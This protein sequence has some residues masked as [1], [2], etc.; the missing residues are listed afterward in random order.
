[1]S[2]PSIPQTQRALI[3]SWAALGRRGSWH[4]LLRRAAALLLALTGL[5]ASAQQPSP[6][7]PPEARFDVFEYRVEG[8]SVLPVETIERAVYPFLGERRT[9]ADVESARA[10][11]EA[12]YRNAGYGTVGVDTPE[13]KITD[14]VVTLQ[15]VQAPVSRLRVVGAKYYSQ[16]RILEKVPSLA[17]G[18]VPNFKLA[19]EQLATV[20]RSADRRVTPL[21][22]PGKTPGTTEVDLVVEDKAPLHGSIELNNKASPNTTNLRLQAS[23]RYDNLWQLEHSIGVQAQVS[24]EDTSQVR[25]FSGSYSV[26][27]GTGLLVFSAIRSNS[28]TVA[29]IGDTSVFGRGSIYGLHRVVVLG[30]DESLSQT[31]TF[32]ADYKNFTESVSVG[33]NQ[34]F[35]TPIHYLPLSLGYAATLTDKQGIWQAGAG[36]ELAVRGLASSEAQFADKRF[37][38]QSNFSILKF[39]VARTQ[40]LPLGLSLFGKLEGQLSDQA[41]ISNEQFVAGGVDSVRGYLEATAVGDK[42]LRGTLE[43]RGPNLARDSWGLIGGLRAHAFVEGA[44]L[45]LNS[46]LPAQQARFGLLGTG[47]GLRL[48]AR[49]TAS[50]AIDVGWP[51]RDA[52]QTQRGTVRVQA[53]G[54]LDF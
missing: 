27:L 49:Q 9:V 37:M 29:G 42:A 15:V 10:A 21:L 54:L 28:N 4:A 8:N 20:N 51:L 34:G 7:K 25:V 53:S 31:L 48:Q 43:L 12:A 32:G 6:P 30:S 40:S 18:E 23:L 26:P 1:M 24:P 33:A 22:R 5:G 2:V 35:N 38:A 41:L 11:L 45:W 17:E 47:V 39:D 52:L 36:L 13:Q 50:F 3:V 46:P 19:T 14:S 44:G 16:E